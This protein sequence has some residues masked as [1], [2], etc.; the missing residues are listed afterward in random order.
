MA[1]RVIWCDA[2]TCP[3]LG[4]QRKSLALSRNDADDPSRKW[5]VHCSS[6]GFRRRGCLPHQPIRVIAKALPGLDPMLSMRGTRAPTMPAVPF[7][8]PRYLRA[9]AIRYSASASIGPLLSARS[10]RTSSRTARRFASGSAHRSQRIAVMASV[11]FFTICFRPNGIRQ[12]HPWGQGSCGRAAAGGLMTKPP[13]SIPNCI[14]LKGITAAVISR[15]YPG[16]KMTTKP[17]QA[18]VPIRVIIFLMMSISIILQVFDAQ[19]RVCGHLARSDSA[20]SLFAARRKKCKNDSPHLALHKESNLNSSGRG[21][22]SRSKNKW[23]SS[24]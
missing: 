8:T 21:R 16:T 11:N 13:S 10:R 15:A 7:S 12:S 24:R 2:A 18:A 9:L 17:V 23:Q 3:H 14:L 1:P 19:A 5:S 4:E 22:P 6:R 20:I